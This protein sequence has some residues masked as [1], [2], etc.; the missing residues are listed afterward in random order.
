MYSD[1]QTMHIDQSSF[2]SRLL[3]NYDLFFLSRFAS[4]VPLALLS[5]EISHWMM[6]P[7]ATVALRPVSILVM[8]VS[9]LLKRS[10]GCPVA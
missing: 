10:C 3:T 2:A 4:L 8:L 7:S 6:F 1:Y 5:P 9:Q